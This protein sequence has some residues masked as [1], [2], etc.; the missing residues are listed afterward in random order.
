V[1]ELTVDINDQVAISLIKFLEHEKK[2]V[3]TIKHE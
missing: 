1:H 2:M 3:T